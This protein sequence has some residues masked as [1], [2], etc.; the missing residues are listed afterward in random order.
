MT[1]SHRSEKEKKERVIVARTTRLYRKPGIKLH[2]CF[3]KIR[4]LT[5]MTPSNIKHSIVLDIIGNSK[6]MKIYSMAYSKFR[7]EKNKKNICKWG[8]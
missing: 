2:R 7:E 6:E 1:L 8:W 3:I 4:K 5:N